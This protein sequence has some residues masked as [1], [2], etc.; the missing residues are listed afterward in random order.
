MNNSQIVLRCDFP[1]TVPAHEQ[2]DF[3]ALTARQRAAVTRRLAVL[4]TLRRGETLA[5]AAARTGVALPTL[6]R[7]LAAFRAKGWRGLAPAWRNPNTGLTPACKDYLL[8]LAE[9]NQRKNKPAWRE[10]CR[11][12]QRREVI[13]G[14][15]G[16]P[17]WPNLPR[18]LSYGN[19]CNL[20]KKHKFELVSFRIGKGAAAT[21]GLLPQTFASRVGL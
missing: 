4:R 14:F 6:N 7:W 21:A 12:W 1:L 13:P 11:R 18:G 3:G 17:G 10:L 2:D 5:A 9:S 15:E 8:N 19:F 16:W 20:A